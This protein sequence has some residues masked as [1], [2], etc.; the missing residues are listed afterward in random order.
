ML[1]CVGKAWIRIQIHAETQFWDLDLDRRFN[2]CGSVTLQ[3]DLNA[4]I[5]KLNTILIPISLCSTS[6][7]GHSLPLSAVGGAFIFVG[8]NFT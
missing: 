1:K 4:D 2:R 6:L 3:T 7:P 8:K 5:I